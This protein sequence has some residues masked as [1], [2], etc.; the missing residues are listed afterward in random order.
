MSVIRPQDRGLSVF[1]GWELRCQGCGSGFAPD[2]TI[3]Y[4][5]AYGFA[6]LMHVGCARTF[7]SELR[8]A[9]ADAASYDA[10]R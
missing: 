7:A 2:E 9:A 1:A 10:E 6:V 5:I 8:E 4:A 3:P